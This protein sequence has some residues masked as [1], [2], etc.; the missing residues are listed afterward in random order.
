MP[1]TRSDRV[2]LLLPPTRQAL[3]LLVPTELTFLLPGTITH[4]KGD[5][6]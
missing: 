3:I 2:Y 6:S 4:R 5:G 1:T